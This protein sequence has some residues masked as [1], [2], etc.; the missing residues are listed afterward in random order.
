MKIWAAQMIL[1]IGY[2][3]T[4]SIVYR[5]LKP[6]N[7]LLDVQGNLHLTDFGLSKIMDDPSKPLNT[8]CGTP[9]Y[10]AP[11]ML[12]SKKVSPLSTSKLPLL[13]ISGSM[14]TDCLCFAGLR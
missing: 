6:E 3:H 11:E 1:A 14:L 8:F 10:L 5:D 12:V 13:V 7:V 2:L 4:L 9:Y